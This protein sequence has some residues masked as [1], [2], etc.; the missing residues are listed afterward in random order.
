MSS[1][2]KALGRLKKKPRFQEFGSLKAIERPE[3]TRRL[4]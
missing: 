3:K 2:W 1:Y 4:L